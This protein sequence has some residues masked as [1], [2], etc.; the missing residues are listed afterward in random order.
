MARPKK[1]NFR[2]RYL[3]KHELVRIWVFKE[4]KEWLQC[5]RFGQNVKQSSEILCRFLDSNECHHVYNEWLSNQADLN[6][7]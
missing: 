6:K 7:E 5:G 3:Q 1:L 4:L 2:E